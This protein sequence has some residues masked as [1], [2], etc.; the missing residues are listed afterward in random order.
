[1]RQQPCPLY[2]GQGRGERRSSEYQVRSTDVD[3]ALTLTL[4]RRE[5]G[6]LWQL[7]P[8]G[9]GTIARLPSTPIPVKLNAIG[10]KTSPERR[11]YVARPVPGYIGPYRLL[12]VI[13]TGHASLIWQA[14]DDDKQR[15][16]GVKTL[17]EKDTKDREQLHYLRW[18]YT[19]GLKLHHPNIIEI[20]PSPRDTSSRSCDGVVLVA[21]Y[22]T[23]V[24]ARAPR[25]S[26]R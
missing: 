11:I 26:P 23:A 5:R 7:L 16:V 20:Y 14:Y 25:K 17:L 13:H 18:E 19:V 15:I 24:F 4:S 3:A 8:E 22:E 1:M 10:Q 2:P 12:N 9:Q 21:E 6:L